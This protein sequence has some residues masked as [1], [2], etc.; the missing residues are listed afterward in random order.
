MKIVLLTIL[1]FLGLWGLSFDELIY[2]KNEAKPSFDCS[3]LKDN[4]KNDDELILCN[5]I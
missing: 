5:K 2:N 1:S 3:R 4:G